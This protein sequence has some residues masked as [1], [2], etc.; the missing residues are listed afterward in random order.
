MHAHGK[1]TLKSGGSR[2]LMKCFGQH[3]HRQDAAVNAPVAARA[4]RWPG[5]R[6]LTPA[7][8]APSPLRTPAPAPATS[9]MKAVFHMASTQVH[10]VH[11]YCL[12]GRLAIP[13]PCKTSRHMS[14]TST[15]S[16]SARYARYRCT[17]YRTCSGRSFNA[18]L[19]RETWAPPQPTGL[20][21][22]LVPQHGQETGDKQK[23]ASNQ[24][25]KGN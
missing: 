24:V 11:P 23:T 25:G 14:C 15:R 3:Q 19:K 7:R 13:E 12:R 21:D 8:T 2:R 9:A 5:G 20:E 4:P 18:P 22:T 6:W 17:P 16:D 1:H 10:D